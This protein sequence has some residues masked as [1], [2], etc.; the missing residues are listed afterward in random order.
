MNSNR[1]S[2]EPDNLKRT[3]LLTKKD[4][5]N[6]KSTYNISINDGVRHTIDSVSVE[7]WVQE[8]GQNESNT[9]F[10]KKQGDDHDFFDKKDVCLIFMNSSQEYMLKTHGNNGIVCVDSTHGLNAYDFELTTILVIDEWGEGFPTACLFTNRKD[11]E[12]FRFFF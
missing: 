1:D 6:I 11:T 4:I 5:H 12:V 8:F 10:Y 9:I 7:L 2:I 3:D